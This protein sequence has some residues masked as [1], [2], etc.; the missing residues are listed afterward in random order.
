MNLQLQIKRNK[1]ETG[2]QS[3]M[4]TDLLDSCT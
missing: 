3:N 4:G 1:I 2:S